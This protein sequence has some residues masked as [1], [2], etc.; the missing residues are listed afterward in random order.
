MLGSLRVGQVGK[1]P[2]GESGSEGGGW[3]RTEGFIARVV[4]EVRPTPTN[5]PVFIGIHNGAI[6]VR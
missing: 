1:G 6:T 4:L 2:F 5:A 3:Y